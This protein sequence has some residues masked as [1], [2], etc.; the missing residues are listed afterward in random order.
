MIDIEAAFEQLEQESRDT[1]ASCDRMDAALSF[2]RRRVR[3][4]ESSAFANG[5]D[6]RMI[7]ARMNAQGEIIAARWPWS[8]L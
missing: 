1:R 7:E 4:I 5:A 2:L 8:D 6:V 3:E